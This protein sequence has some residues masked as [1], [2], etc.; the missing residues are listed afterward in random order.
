MIAITNERSGSDKEYIRKLRR[1]I[2][3]DD[4]RGLRK[5]VKKEVPN[6]RKILPKYRHVDVLPPKEE[7]ERGVK[8]FNDKEFMNWVILDDIERINKGE[9]RH[10]SDV[11]VGSGSDYVD[12][13]ME[14]IVRQRYV[15][16]RTQDELSHN[17]AQAKAKLDVMKK[18]ASMDFNL[19]YDEQTDSI[20][21]PQGSRSYK[22]KGTFSHED[23]HR[24]FGKTKMR[25]KIGRLTKEI[26]QLSDERD[27]LLMENDF[28][29]DEESLEING[30]VNE[31]LSE[32]SPLLKD[33]TTMNEG[34]AHEITDQYRGERIG[35]DQLERKAKAYGVNK[36]VF[37]YCK[38]SARK[39]INLFGIDSAKEYF[40]RVI[41]DAYDSGRKGTDLLKDR[42]ESFIGSDSE[43][44]SLYRHFEKQRHYESG[45]HKKVKKSTV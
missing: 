32:L 9:R 37:V 42:I 25:K 3:V 41:D 12:K 20:Q 44:G 36:D 10:I 16:Y 1:K 27:R 11:P 13:N 22:K 18:Y 35:Q 15:S 30:E 28:K 5:K 4:I 7:R 38:D 14:R 39:L 26:F 31:K 19:R 6:Y 23:T 21:I 43:K 17:E 33:Y 29:Y 45:I 40:A 24:Y 2:L 8:Y 34:F